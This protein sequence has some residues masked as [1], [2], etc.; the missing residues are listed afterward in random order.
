MKRHLKI[1]IYPEKDGLFPVKIVRQTHRCTEFGGEKRDNFGIRST[2]VRLCSCSFPAWSDASILF[3]RGD[4]R[5]RDKWLAKVPS[6][7]I[8]KVIALVAAYNVKHGTPAVASWS[9]GRKIRYIG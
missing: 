4:N 1:A 2:R 5:D 6:K 9:A 8:G 3:L 7:F